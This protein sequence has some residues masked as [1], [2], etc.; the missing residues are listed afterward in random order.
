MEPVRV[1]FCP[2]YYGANGGLFDERGVP[3]ED[4]DAE[5]TVHTRGKCDRPF[6]CGT[7]PYL[8]QWVGKLASQGMG[9]AWECIACLKQTKK[10]DKESGV[11]RFIPGY[12][13]AGRPPVPEGHPD[14]DKDNP[15]LAGCTRCGWES[16]FLQLII[17]RRR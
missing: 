5:E 12:F 9:I 16:S 1:A 14:Y 7:C 11:I 8:H 15:P 2:I 17:R 6:D 13:Q 10:M 4:P 3:M